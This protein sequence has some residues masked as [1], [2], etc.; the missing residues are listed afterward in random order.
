VDSH[1]LTHR[2]VVADGQR[3]I[4]ACLVKALRKPADHCHREDAATGPDFRLSADDRMRDQLHAILEDGV[5]SD[6]AERPNLDV[7]ANGRS[8]FDDGHRV[9]A[10]GSG[11]PAHSP[12]L[13]RIIA[14]ISASA[15]SAPSTLA[16]QWNFQILPRC[17]CL[18]T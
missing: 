11:D 4:L 14:P 17:F 8:V 10:G 1:T 15:T 7:F 3:R 12:S 5:L 16:S 18:M 6:R 9:D 13:R 2:A